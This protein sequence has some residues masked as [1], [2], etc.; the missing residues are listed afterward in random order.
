ME[1]IIYEE[2][3][4][5]NTTEVYEF[6]GS[7]NEYICELCGGSGEYEDDYGPKGCLLCSSRLI[8]FKDKN[9]DFQTADWGDEILKDENGGLTLKRNH[10]YE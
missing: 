6:I 3:P 9:G 1:N 4:N 2:H 10:R 8:P 5:D 7:E